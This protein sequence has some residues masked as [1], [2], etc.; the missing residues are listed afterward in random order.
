MHI[1]PCLRALYWLCLCHGLQFTLLMHH[2]KTLQTLGHSDVGNSKSF[3]WSALQLG[4]SKVC[5]LKAM[6]YLYNWGPKS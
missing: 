3:H 1:K 2:E 5:L 6:Q 4:T